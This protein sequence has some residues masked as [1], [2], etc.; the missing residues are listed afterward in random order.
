[1]TVAVCLHCGAYKVGAFTRC[2]AC[3]YEPHDD[4]SLTK[5]LMVT[6]HYLDAA[7]LK[8]VATRVKAGV[9]LA[10]DPASMKA[11][12]VSRTE[13]DRADKRVRLIAYTLLTFFVA[14]AAFGWL[15]SSSH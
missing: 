7:Q 8:D 9:A 14:I 15:R 6:D 12:W 2:A 10:F 1:M 11:L 3:G 4:E 5:H 13:L